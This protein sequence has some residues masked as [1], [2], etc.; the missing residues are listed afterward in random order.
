MVEEVLEGLTLG[1][2]VE[3]LNMGEVVEV[4]AVI[5]M[6]MRLVDMMVGYPFSVLEGEVAVVGQMSLDKVEQVEHGVEI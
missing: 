5:I 2:V 1:L 6:I 4:L 3:M